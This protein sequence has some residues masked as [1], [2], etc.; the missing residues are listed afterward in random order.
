MG[1]I[2]LIWISHK[3]E[4]NTTLPFEQKTC[5]VKLTTVLISTQILKKNERPDNENKKK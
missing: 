4:K 2:D 5:Q 1:R 3:N